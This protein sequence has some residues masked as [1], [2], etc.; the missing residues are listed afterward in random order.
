MTL[1]PWVILDVPGY[2]PLSPRQ[3]AVAWAAKPQ[4]ICCQLRAALQ[5]LFSGSAKTWKRLGRFHF[6]ICKMGVVGGC[7]WHTGN[8]PSA[9]SDCY[10]W[11]LMGGQK[12]MPCSLWLETTC[13][14]GTWGRLSSSSTSLVQFHVC[15]LNHALLP[16]KGI[17]KNSRKPSPRRLSLLLWKPVFLFSIFQILPPFK[18]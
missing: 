13:S 12:V 14:M 5:I 11:N 4:I 18:A 8:A 17:A 16:L 3:L 2:R 15:F 9:D 7:A 6:I 1:W 10:Y